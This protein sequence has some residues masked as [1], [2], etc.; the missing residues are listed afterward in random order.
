MESRKG[1][2]LSICIPTYNRSKSL[3]IC[4][5]S[6]LSQT[7]GYEEDVEV[8]VSDNCSDDDTMQVVEWAR[9]HGP[10]R[11]YR[12]ESNIGAGP[13]FFLLSNVLARGE[14]CW[15]IGDDDFLRKD[16]LSRLI[17]ALKENSEVDMF[18]SNCMGIDDTLL[19]RMGSPMSNI[20][21]PE[22]SET[23]SKNLNDFEL[24]TFDDLFDPE[25][26]QYCLAFLPSSIFRRE[27][28]SEA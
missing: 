13:N 18:F 19:G 12:N 14:F 25:I 20:Q 21:L 2:L 7:K 5:L 17:L 27:L 26:N 9:G 16:S 28:W 23:F 6:I 8:V 15:L 1:P 10:L 11:Y 24:K 3:R 4:L 22:H